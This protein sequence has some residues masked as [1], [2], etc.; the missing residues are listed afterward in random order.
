MGGQAAYRAWKIASAHSSQDALVVSRSLIK[1]VNLLLKDKLIQSI[2]D[3]FK[4][5][6]TTASK[7]ERNLSIDIYACSSFFRF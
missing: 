5:S 2:I 4:L 1:F 7:L 6:Y 3:Q